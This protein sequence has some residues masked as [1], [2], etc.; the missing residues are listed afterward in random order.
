MKLNRISSFKNSTKLAVND[1]LTDKVSPITQKLFPKGNQLL[2]LFQKAE[3]IPGGRKILS[4]FLGRLIPYTGTIP[5][6]IEELSQNSSA[7][8]FT[9]QKKI[10]NHLNCVHAI[11]LA[12]LGEFSTGIICM[13]NVVGKDNFILLGLEI[14]Y[15]K[16]A[17]GKIT[18]RCSISPD[19]LKNNWKNGNTLRL[20]SHLFD[21]KNILVAKVKAS[22]KIKSEE[23]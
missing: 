17:R 8:S 12:N 15:L 7:V 10:Q 11:A 9:E 18:A 5:F 19:Y 23:K 6:E 20:E 4:R 16:K 2:S 13:A 3:R 14:E 22:W 1:F 21:S